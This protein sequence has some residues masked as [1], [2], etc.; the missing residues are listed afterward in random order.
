M[1][2]S[3]TSSIEQVTPAARESIRA[4]L[5]STLARFSS[6]IQQVS[7]LLIDENG[8]RGGVDKVCRA[9]VQMLGLGT[10]TTTARHEKLMAAVSEAAQRARRI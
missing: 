5:S 4:L 6:R 7:V 3:V 1:R 8:P 9:N 10:V 2:V